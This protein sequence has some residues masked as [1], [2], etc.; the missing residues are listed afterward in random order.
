MKSKQ[1]KICYFIVLM[2]FFC[3]IS[4]C[5]NPS[6]VNSFTIIDSTKFEIIFELKF[7]MDTLNPSEKLVDQQALQIGN[8]FSKYFS[9][10]LAKSDSINTVL[11]E[12]GADYSLAPPK[13]ANSYEVIKNKN[14]K[15]ITVTDRSDDII[16]RYSEPYPSIN[17]SI[18]NEKKIIQQYSCQRATGSFRGRNYEAWFAIDIPIHEG[19]YKFGGLPGIILEIND[20]QMHYHFK[21]ITLKTLD[22]KEPIKIRNWHYTETTRTELNE[23]LKRKYKNPVN[24]YKSRG[25]PIMI[26][27]DGKFVEAPKDFSLPYNPI[28]LE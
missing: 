11:E 26:N 20:S 1:Q 16:F 8:H 23:F 7:V 12:Q 19:P 18:H 27:K 4:V 14:A 6:F 21:C 22:T 25:V 13:G 3:N 24:Y 15:T 10:L 9:I 17:W 28:E 5:Q 2:I